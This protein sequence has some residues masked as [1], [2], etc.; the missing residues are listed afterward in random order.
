[1]RGGEL[2]TVEAALG[3]QG[4]R[5]RI[6]GDDLLDL[7][8]VEGARLDVETLTRDRRGRDRRGKRRA[9]D[10]LAASVEELDEE[11]GAVR[12]HR[13]GDPAIAGDDLVLIAR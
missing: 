2:D 5:A 7:L 6:A 13:L 1:V 11:A 12:S 4:G 10:H 3:G 9:G 8:C